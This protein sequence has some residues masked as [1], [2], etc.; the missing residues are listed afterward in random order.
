MSKASFNVDFVA[1]R[2]QLDRLGERLKRGELDRDN[3]V[4]LATFR[5]AFIDSTN[6][7]AS[8]IVGNLGNSKAI[9]S[10][11]PA[12]STPSIIAKLRRESVR[13]TQ[14]QD[15][16]G[17]RVVVSKIS[18]Q[19]RIVETIRRLYPSSRVVD[20]RDQPHHGY[21]AVHVIVEEDGR[22]V[23]VQ[24]RTS[25]Q[26]SWAQLSEKYADVFD[27]RIKYGQGPARALANLEYLSKYGMN[28]E[29]REVA[30]DAFR[31]A[32]VNDLHRKRR[33]GK[34]S[35]VDRARLAEYQKLRDQ[36]RDSK[37]AM[38]RF[39]KEQIEK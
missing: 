15:I 11:R 13:L 36:K 33:S 26:N 20:H 14:M 28:L 9:I 24:V 37:Q 27:Q 1:T 29:R 5:N 32:E 8:R 16:G 17:V 34:M 22:F 25:V 30:L 23:E 18:V 39:C 19:N 10:Q 35:K 4:A 2:T 38:L 31:R 3:L 12:K 21:R 6:K 7:V